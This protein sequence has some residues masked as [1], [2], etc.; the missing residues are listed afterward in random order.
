MSR[1]VLSENACLCWDDFRSVLF[2]LQVLRSLAPG[3]T[4][5]CSHFC[6]EYIFCWAMQNGHADRIPPTWQPPGRRLFFYICQYM[7]L[8]QVLH[9]L[10]P[11]IT[12]SVATFVGKTFS[13]GPCPWRQ[14]MSTPWRTSVFL[15]EQT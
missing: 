7:Q 1:F 15:I 14:N 11:S 6:G 8:L 9:S 3:I 5:G 4:I 2:I 12:I 10:A 13:A